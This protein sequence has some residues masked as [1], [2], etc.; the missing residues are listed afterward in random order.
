MITPDELKQEVVSWASEVGVAPKEIHVRD[1]KRKWA[2][3]SSKGRLTFAT[4]LL[5][6]PKETRSRAIVHE[7]LHLRYPTH[8][9]MFN[10]LLDIH[11]R[12]EAQRLKS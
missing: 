5:H 10:R 2:S 4:S 3:C 7:L 11:L 12:K 9:R 1:M 8:G 6:E